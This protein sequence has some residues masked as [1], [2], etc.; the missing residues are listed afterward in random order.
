MEGDPPLVSPSMKGKVVCLHDGF[1]LD[2]VEGDPIPPRAMVEFESG[3]RLLVDRSMK[4]QNV[5]EIQTD[6]SGEQTMAVGKAPW[7]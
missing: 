3:F 7:V 5:A 6:T 1:H 2:L 4:W